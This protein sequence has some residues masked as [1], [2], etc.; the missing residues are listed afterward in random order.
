MENGSADDAPI[1]ELIDLIRGKPELWNATADDYRNTKMKKAAWESVA[2]GTSRSGGI[3]VQ[4]CK[5]V[6][7]TFV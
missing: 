7:Q 5:F 2:I 3:L 4:R 6:V 1:E